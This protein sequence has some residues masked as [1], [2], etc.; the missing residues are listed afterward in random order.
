MKRIVFVIFALFVAA[1]GDKGSDSSTTN[2]GQ[3]ATTPLDPRC[4]NGSTN[5]QNGVYNQNYQYGWMGYPG[6]QNGYNYTNYFSQ[7]GFCNCPPGS[8]PTY[9]STSGLGCL[10][11]EYINPYMTFTYYWQ[12]SFNAGFSYGY[13]G[14]G[15]GYNM[16][17][18]PT[19]ITQVSNISGYPQS[20]SACFNDV[21]QSCA[22]NQANSCGVGAICRPTAAASGMGICFRN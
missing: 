1:C 8:R 10:R 3:I 19:N 17:D 11:N 13:N 9:N 22:V 4:Y 2:T 15:A 14:Y 20:S 5:C 18:Y 21:V 7:Y 12:V 16:N 6:F